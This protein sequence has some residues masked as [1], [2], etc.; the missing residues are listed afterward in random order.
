MYNV[1][2]YIIC[3]LLGGGGGGGTTPVHVC[4]YLSVAVHFFVG[5]L[6]KVLCAQ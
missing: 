3:T 2:V 6:E 4:I 5:G 1:H